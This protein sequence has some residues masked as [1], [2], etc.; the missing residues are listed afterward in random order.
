MQTTKKPIP[1]AANKR[2]YNPVP[3]GRSKEAVS[4]ERTK[5]LADA[6]VKHFGSV[7]AARDFVGGIM[8]SSFRQWRGGYQAMGPIHRD[9]IEKFFA[10]VGKKV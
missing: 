1:I 7:E 6:L 4:K 9:R 10:R 3:K 8:P 5:E 2:F